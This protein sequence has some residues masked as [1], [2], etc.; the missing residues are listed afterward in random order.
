[1]TMFSVGI[2]NAEHIHTHQTQPENPGEERENKA[3]SEKFS[4]FANRNL[5]VLQYSEMCASLTRLNNNNNERMPT[6]RQ[7]TSE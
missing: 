4:S 5:E 1:M 7:N 3:A 6:S 2:K